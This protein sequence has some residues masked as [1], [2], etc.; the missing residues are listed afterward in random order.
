MKRKKLLAIFL[1]ATF[2]FSGCEG[3]KPE[4]EQATP[5]PKETVKYRQ[6]DFYKMAEE[7]V[8]EFNGEPKTRFLQRDMLGRPAL[9]VLEAGRDDTESKY[10][11]ILEYA[12]TEGGEWEMKVICMKSLSKRFKQEEDAG[13]ITR[14]IIRGDDGNLYGL[15]QFTERMDSGPEQYR[16]SVLKFDEGQDSLEEIKL[17]FEGENGDVSEHTLSNDVSNFRVLEDGTPVLMMDNT[18][19][20]HFDSESGAILIKNDDVPVE[21]F[22][23]NIGFGESEIIYYSTGKKLFERRN[24]ETMSAEGDFGEEVPEEKRGRD[25]YYD[26]HTEE[27]QMYV[28]NTYGLYRLGEMGKEMM[29]TPVSSE[30]SFDGLTDTIIYDVMVDS[31]EDVYL[32]VSRAS[33]SEAM[34]YDEEREFGVIQY[35][36]R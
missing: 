19:Q 3:A 23:K 22:E 28:F 35:S 30:G 17:Q 11:Q 29:L 13:I 36:S 33:E 9:Y 10:G 7:E 5:L 31:K 25:W 32:L 6:I 15:V 2:L 18:T 24:L 12:L 4:E 20:I 14:F 21:M 16:F 8:V 27:W 1:A 26:T 34:S